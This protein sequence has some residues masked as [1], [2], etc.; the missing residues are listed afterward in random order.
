MWRLAHA[1][2]N[3][4]GSWWRVDRVR[5][6][7]RAGRLSRIGRRGLLRISLK[8]IEVCR[9]RVVETAAGP[10]VV[11]DCSADAGPGVLC[12]IPRAAA[13]SCAVWWVEGGQVRELSEEEVEVFG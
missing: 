3:L 9:R 5:T 8:N 2:Y 7:V 11:Y 1:L 10:G 12:V 6:S 4:I 13:R